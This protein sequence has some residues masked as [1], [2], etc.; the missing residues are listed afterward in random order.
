MCNG[1]GRRPSVMT[2]FPCARSVECGLEFSTVNSSDLVFP[3][4]IPALC[5][6]IPGFLTLLKLVRFN[7]RS[8]NFYKVIL[9]SIEF[10][11]SK[12]QLWY[13]LVCL[14]LRFLDF[15]KIAIVFHS[16]SEVVSWIAEARRGTVL[17]TLVRF[18]E[19]FMNF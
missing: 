11:R 16:F 10:M 1:V 15:V 14:C 9:L 5:W 12:E 6:T 18:C 3:G 2:Y 13:S 8:R 7:E 4:T 19:Q 17:L